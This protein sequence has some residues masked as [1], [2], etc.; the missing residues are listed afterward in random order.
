M[1]NDLLSD[2][3]F[4]LDRLATFLK[5]VEAG[6]IADAADRDP[7]LQSLYSKHKRDL[8]KALDEK[9]FELR[10]GTLKPTQFGR[11]LAAVVKSF[12]G[13]L[14]DLQARKA[15]IER[16]ITIGAGDS[17]FHWLLLPITNTLQASFRSVS[18][19]FRNL[20]T[21]QI[22][23]AVENGDIEI[24][25][26]REGELP[27]SVIASPF[28]AMRFGLFYEPTSKHTPS[29]KDIL[30][31]NGLISLSGKG[32]YASAVRKLLASIDP[33]LEPASYFDS[34]PMIENALIAMRTCSILPVAAKD[35][36]ER[37]GFKMLQPKEL[38]PFSRNYLIFSNTAN[39]LQRPIIGEIS[40]KLIELIG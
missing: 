2:Y 15:N 23:E 34:L 16:P 31:T 36:L 3:R 13:A 14:A 22:I 10:N 12:D 17:V 35:R 8:E 27:S 11:E 25:I 21:L 39:Q 20:T 30:R 24:G 19:R 28:R 26:A 29:L 5:I 6:S 18:F 32:Q 4:S 33:K 9:L 38:E 37:Q 1:T 40:N 7:S